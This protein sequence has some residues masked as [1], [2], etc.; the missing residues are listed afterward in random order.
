MKVS[1][2]GETYSVAGDIAKII[3]ANQRKDG[4]YESN[5]YQ[6]TWTFGHLST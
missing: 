1:V 6:V 4:Y 2:C 5:G 3:V